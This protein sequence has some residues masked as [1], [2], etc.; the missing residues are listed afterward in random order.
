A[1]DQIGDDIEGKAAGERFGTTISM[2]DSIT[3]AIGT[4]YQTSTGLP[5]TI[6][7]SYVSI[8]RWNGTN[9]AQMGSNIEG[10]STGEFGS[11]ISMPDTYT[12]A[13]G[14]PRNDSNGRSSGQVR[15]YRWNVLANAW[16]QK[17]N[18]IHGEAAGDQS[19]IYQYSV[20]MPDSNTV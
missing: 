16:F 17:G 18:L 2:P 11:S 8:F 19:G 15:I 9:W 1:W 4:P 3:V 12:I 13:I 7:P 6:S 14:D 10:D 20:S 5:T